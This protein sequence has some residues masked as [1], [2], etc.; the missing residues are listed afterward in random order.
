MSLMTATDD[1]TRHSRGKAADQDNWYTLSIELT[2]DVNGKY[3]VNWFIQKDGLPAQLKDLSDRRFQLSVK[4]LSSIL[5]NNCHVV[6]TVPLHMLQTSPVFHNS[7]PCRGALLKENRLP[8]NARAGRA[9]SILIGRAG[10]LE[11]S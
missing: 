3:L 7:S 10:G 8:E 6:P 11:V 2:V 5:W 4:H 9:L 1:T